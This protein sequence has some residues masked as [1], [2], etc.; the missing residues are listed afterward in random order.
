[1]DEHKNILALFFPFNL[2]AVLWELLEIHSISIKDGEFGI[3]RAGYALPAVIRGLTLTGMMIR[4]QMMCHQLG[5]VWWWTKWGLR[6]HCL[7]K[8]TLLSKHLWST[9]ICF[10]P[11]TY[12]LMTFL[13]FTVTHLS[14][15]PI[16]M[17]NG[18][19]NIS[20]T[21]F[22]T[23]SLADSCRQVSMKRDFMVKQIIENR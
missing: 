6:H 12:A 21:A 22:V 7:T 14:D 4:H 20:G 2:S 8:E 9:L 5:K 13:H 3:L 15:E 23:Q 17:L 16:F 19:K 10:R 18:N 11:Q 1:M